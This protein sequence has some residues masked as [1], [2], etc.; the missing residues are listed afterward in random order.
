MKKLNIMLEDEFLPPRPDPVPATAKNKFLSVERKLM[1]LQ[2][3]KGRH[4]WAFIFSLSFILVQ[5]NSVL[6]LPVEYQFTYDPT[7]GLTTIQNDITSSS[8]FDFHP[9]VGPDA[10]KE[11]QLPPGDT[12]TIDQFGNVAGSFLDPLKQVCNNKLK[13]IT[14]TTRVVNIN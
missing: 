10:L 1:K 9:L 11:F 8:V 5:S 7:T 3:V 4:L 14:K 6:A 2:K 12:V 13:N